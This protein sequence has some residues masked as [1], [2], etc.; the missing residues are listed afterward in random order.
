MIAES[1]EDALDNDGDE[2]EVDTLVSQ[3]LEEL[4]IDM[5]EKMASAPS[6]RVGEAQGAASAQKKAVAQAEGEGPSSSS[7]SS[8]YSNAPP[9]NVT[10]DANDPDADL[11]ARVANLGK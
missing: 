9:P 8:S 4:G 3:A 2:K 5:E 6:T 11:F 10:V 7:S 1:M